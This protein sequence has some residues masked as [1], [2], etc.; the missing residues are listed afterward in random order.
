MIGERLLGLP[1]S[2]GL[3]CSADV[4]FMRRPRRFPRLLRGFLAG[5]PVREM[6][7]ADWIR[8]AGCGNGF[9]IGRTRAVRSIGGLGATLM[10]PRR[11][12]EF[13]AG[14]SPC[15][16]LCATVLIEAILVHGRR[17]RSTSLAGLL[18]GAKERNDRRQ[19]P[20]RRVGYHRSMFGDGRPALTGE[21]T[22][23][24]H[25]R[26]PVRGARGGRSITSPPTPPVTVTPFALSYI[27]R[28]TGRHAL[29]RRWEPPASRDR[30][31]ARRYGAGCSTRPGALAAEIRRRRGRLDPVIRRAANAIDRP[32]GSFQA[33]K[34]AC[35][36]M[37]IEDL[38]PP[39][40]VMPASPR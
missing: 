15:N 26:R 5:A 2:R 14:R 16:P 35:A 31:D 38:T 23:V 3:K 1:R 17:K 36:D 37:M 10:R 9:A 29:R 39:A 11:S 30:R 27:T 22:P 13:S 7:A 25:A 28:A 34:H 21:R 24:L 20:R 33:V 18:T 8:T 4:N 19:W 12:V 40:T 6:A 32:I